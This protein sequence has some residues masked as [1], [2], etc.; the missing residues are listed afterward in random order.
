MSVHTPAITVHSRNALETR[1][2]IRVL[3]NQ[4]PSRNHIAAGSESLQQAA[5]PEPVIVPP[6]PVILN[7]NREGR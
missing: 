4:Q 1:P 6:E 5:T 3:R 7:H 2:G